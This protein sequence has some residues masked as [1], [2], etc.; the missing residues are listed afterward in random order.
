MFKHHLDVLWVRFLE[1]GDVKCNA[2]I[3]YASC[4]FCVGLDGCQ[5]C[6]CILHFTSEGTYQAHEGIWIVI[7]LLYGALLRTLLRSSVA[8]VHLGGRLGEGDVRSRKQE[9]M[10]VVV[11]QKLC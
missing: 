9:V 6:I 1:V 5:I 2:N 10:L 3:V 7:F 11:L 8:S 4:D